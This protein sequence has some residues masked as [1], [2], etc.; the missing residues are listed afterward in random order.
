MGWR[1]Y[2]S[3]IDSE[4]KSEEDAVKIDKVVDNISENFNK[5]FDNAL[6]D[7][8]DE[9]QGWLENIDSNDFKKILDETKQEIKN[10]FKR[11]WSLGE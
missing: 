4:L 8:L 3:F 1:A 7:L 5:L 11:E 2:G 9:D 6:N 10:L